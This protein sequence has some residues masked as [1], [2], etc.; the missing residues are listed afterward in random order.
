VHAIVTGG[1]LST[2]TTGWR[3]AQRRY[4][5][6]VKAM[7]PVWRAKML[8]C[9]EHAYR[10]GAFDGFDDFVDPQGFELL[11]Q[12]AAKPSWVVYA[13]T[14]FAQG[15]HVLA[16]LGRYTHRVGISNS[17]L[18]AVS[19]QAVT[20]ATKHG[21][22]ETVSPVEFLR[23]FV[24]HVLPDGLHKIRH[25]GLYASAS[26]ERR[27]QA[28]ACLGCTLTAA[29]KLDWRDRLAALTGRDLATCPR[30]GGA[31]VSVAVA[32]CRAPPGLAA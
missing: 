24:Q 10:D 20:F 28:A 23:R 26:A 25:A 15:Q 19:P 7:G 21:L 6:P 1:G 4:L 22:T 2:E 3:P 13:K 30:C 11:M 8:R 17:R 18:L 5:F 31:L 29:P 32:R 14:S 27:E 16:Y 9:L 12:R